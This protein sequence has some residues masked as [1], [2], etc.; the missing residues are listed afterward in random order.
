MDSAREACSRQYPRKS[1][2]LP[3]F[4]RVRQLQLQLQLELQLQL[5]L[6]FLLIRVHRTGENGNGLK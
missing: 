2:Q 4:I 5:Q 3:V 1:R 6:Q